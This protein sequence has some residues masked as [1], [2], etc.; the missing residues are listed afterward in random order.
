MNVHSIEFNRLNTEYV[1]EIFDNFKPENG[2]HNESIIAPKSG[3]YFLD[4]I[5]HE[6][7]SNPIFKGDVIIFWSKDKT[8]CRDWLRDGV[9][10]KNQGA[11]KPSPPPPNDPILYKTYYHLI[12]EDRSIDKLVVK[13][14][15]FTLHDTCPVLIH[16]IDKTKER[17]VELDYQPPV[18]GNLKNKENE[19]GY[20]RTL[21]SVYSQLKQKVS[22][23]NPHL[24]YKESSKKNGPR[25]LK[26][27]QNLRYVSF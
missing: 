19:E 10:W 15:Y 27:C 12:R 26:Q 2:N 6:I 7:I 4:E 11:K 1:K 5:Q 20:L 16:Y 14:V 25:N 18:H 13:D 17:N 21:P 24:V 9:S 22:Q 8:K 23:K 3:I